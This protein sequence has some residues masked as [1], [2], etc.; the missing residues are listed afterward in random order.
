ME[1][2]HTYCSLRK[3]N[4]GPR[5]FKD[6]I[7]LSLYLFNYSF[8]AEGN[9]EMTD[10]YI[11]LMYADHATMHSL[12][13]WKHMGK[14]WST[15]RNNHAREG[16]PKKNVRIFWFSI[17]VSDSDNLKLFSFTRHYNNLLFFNTTLLLLEFMNFTQASKCHVNVLTCCYRLHTPLFS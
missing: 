10:F 14:R 6:T 17:Q 5:V 7:F 11:L 3:E 1:A 12:F 4:D 15:L 13:F 2:I 8:G 16:L 9:L